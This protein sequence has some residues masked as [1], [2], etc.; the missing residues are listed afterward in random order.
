MIDSTRAVD[1]VKKKY[2]E[3]GVSRVGQITTGWIISFEGI[4]GKRMMISPVHVSKLDGEIKMFFPPDH[5]DELEHYKEI[6]F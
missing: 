3:L 2:P 5:R 6:K 1:L 4:E